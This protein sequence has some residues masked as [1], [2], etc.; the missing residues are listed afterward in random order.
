MALALYRR[1]RRDC[2]AGHPEELRTSEYDERKKGF[3]RCECPIFVSGTLQRRF[4]RQT[5]AQWE[6]DAARAVASQLEAADDWDGAIEEPLPPKMDESRGQNRI[7]IN[8]ATDAYLSRCR[9]RAIRPPSYAKYRTFVNQLHAFARDRGYVYLDQFG[10]ADMDLFYG[11]WKDG[12]KAKAKKLDRLK[13]FV[14]FA[15]KRKWLAEDIAGDLQAPAG[16]S[17]PFPKAPFTD[18]ELD[19]IYAACDRLGAPAKRNWTGEDAKDFIYLSVYTGLRISDVAT[20][21]ITKRLHGNNVF[22]RAQKN[23][24]NVYTWIPDWLVHRLKARE[25][26]YGPLIFKCGVSLTMKQLTD[27]WRGKRINTIFELAG[28]F[29]EKPT[30][31]RFRH[32][33]VRILLAKGVPLADVAE[34]IGDTEEVVRRH[35]AKWVPERQARLTKILQDAFDDKPKRKLVA[36]R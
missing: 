30:P 13:S 10:V 26:K 23:N 1:H 12:I 33:F 21:D 34:L 11:S 27:I 8:D 31:H 20:F 19:R 22:I 3:R 18:D 36:I 35:Y 4:R 29:D 15:V 7:A 16:S 17:I 14:K 5:T 32:T 24:A 28:P 25:Q 2:K 6:W 9:D